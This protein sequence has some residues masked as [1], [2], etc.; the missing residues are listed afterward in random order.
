MDQKHDKCVLNTVRKKKKLI[1]FLNVWDYDSN[2]Y[3]I[4]NLLQ[5]LGQIGEVQR[6]VLHVIKVKFLD[7]VSYVHVCIF[8]PKEKHEV[9]S[10]ITRQ[11]FFTVFREWRLISR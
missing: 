9:S 2:E 3:C 5:Y 6:K 4:F 8:M 1:K 7:G 11:I 10:L